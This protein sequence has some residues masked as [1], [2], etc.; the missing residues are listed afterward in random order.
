MFV[1]AHLS[2][3]HLAPLPTPR[4]S[5]L[6]SKRLTGFLNWQRKRRDIHSADMLERIAADLH[7]QSPDHIAVSGD[8]IN[9]S[10]PEEFVAGRRWLAALG[11]TSDVTFV[12][13]N[14][15]AYIRRMRTAAI[16]SWADNMQGDGDNEVMFP[17]IRRR[18]PVALLGLS[19]AIPTAPFRATGKVG[20]EQLERLR[21][22]LVQ[23]STQGVFRIVM[24][25][26]PPASEPGRENQRLLDGEALVAV[27]AEAGAELV[28]HGHEHVNSVS[29]LAGPDHRRIPVVGVP[30]ASAA[31]GGHWEAAGYNLYHIDGRDTEWR[32]RMVSRAVSADHG[33]V[34]TGQRVIVWR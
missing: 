30:S 14:H 18:G 19:S 7:L 2:D 28:L 26:H 20:S 13:G 29:W 8:L 12:P 25:H 5:D 16:Q 3:P 1:L 33:I 27:L 31:L 15:D 10:L 23:L 6:A 24:I 17:F 34:E 4:F 22:S 9:L 11:R 21:E 32:C